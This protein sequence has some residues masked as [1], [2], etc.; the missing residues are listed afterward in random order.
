MTYYPAGTLPVFSDKRGDIRHIMPDGARAAS[1]AYIT[2]NKGDIRADHYHKKD[3]HY[4]FCVSGRL[5]Y[6]Y[7]NVEEKGADY[8][9]VILKPGDVIFTDVNE[10]HKFEFLEDGAFIA[11]SSEARNQEAYEADTFRTK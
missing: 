6:S 2:G 1:V 5:K 10:W 4:C 8:Q 7:Q 11:V 9:F 3:T